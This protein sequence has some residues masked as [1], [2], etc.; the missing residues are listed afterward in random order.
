MFYDSA[1]NHPNL[2]KSKKFYEDNEEEETLPP[3]F[4]IVIISDTHGLHRDLP[5]KLPRGDILIH[6]GDFSNTGTEKD[7]KDF[8]EWFTSQPHFRKVFIAGNHEL[9]LDREYYVDRGAKR[10]HGQ[11]LCKTKNVIG[12]DVET[13]V[14]RIKPCDYADFCTDIIASAAVYAGPPLHSG[15]VVYDDINQSTN[16][17]YLQDSGVLLNREKVEEGVNSRISIDHGQQHILIYGSPWQPEFCDWAFNCSRGSEIRS[18][19]D[20]IPT[21]VPIDILVT[22]GPPYGRFISFFVL[23]L[24]CPH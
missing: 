14:Q 11:N 10:F 24:W 5:F 17:F 2:C 23:F 21:D 7:I 18:K 19:F 3:G 4:R 1:Q 8:T 22:H 15:S 13:T 12:K 6:A 9:T 20:S 16:T